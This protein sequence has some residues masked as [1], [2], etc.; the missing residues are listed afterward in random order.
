MDRRSGDRRRRLSRLAPLRSAGCARRRGALR[1]QLLHRH[2]SATSSTCCEPALRADAARRDVPALRRG[3]RDL[4]PGLPGLADALPVR[5]GADHQ[6]Q[7]ARRHQHA[8]SGQARARRASCRRRPRRCTAIPRCIR[9]PRATGGASTPSARA[10]ATTR[11]SAARRRSSST[12][13]ASTSVDIKVVRIFN[14]YGPR[15]HPNDGR[16]VSNFI[17][18]A[19]RGEDVTIYGDGAQ[20]RSFCY[21]DDLI[22]GMIRMMDSDDGLRRP[23]QPR[24]PG[25]VHDAR[26]G[27]EGPAP[28]ALEVA[29]RAQGRCR[30]TTRSSASRTSPWRE[31]SSAGSP[32]CALEDGLEETIAYFPAS[33]SQALKV[34]AEHSWHAWRLAT[35]VYG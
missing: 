8:G 21:V 33:S 27:G 10:A 24:Q 17:V 20:T 9:R 22:E 11:A 25:R 7:R 14:T 32:R 4:Q 2:A 26:A 6:D 23:G 15:M 1:R 29:D 34:G 19:L 13:S 31:R 30:P 35:R 28:H 12:T 18:Q 16:V 5:P 3:R